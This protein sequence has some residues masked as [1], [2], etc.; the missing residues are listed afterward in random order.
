MM[1]FGDFFTGE[2]NEILMVEEGTMMNFKEKC[3]LLTYLQEKSYVE[4]FDEKD[5][6]ILSELSYD[7]DAYIRAVVAETLVESSDEKGEQ[8]LLRLTKDHDWLVRTDACDSLCISESVDTY[9]L[10]KEI[11]KKDTSGLVRGYAILSLENIAN[12]INRE[13]ELIEFLEERIIKEKVQFTRINT[14]TALYKLGREK[15]LKNLLSMFNSKKYE[16]RHSVVESLHEIFDDS[17]KNEIITALLEHKKVETAGSVIYRINDIIEEIFLIDLKEK[18]DEKGIDEK[19]FCRLKEISVEGSCNN[20]GL[21]ARVLVNSNLKEGEKILQRLAHDNDL[22]VRME[23]CDSLCNGKS[24]KTYKLLKNIGEKDTSGLVRG[25]AIASLGDVAIEI[26]QQHDLIEFL[27]CRLLNEKVEFARI[28]IFSVLYSLGIEEYLANL[29]SMLNSKRY[30]NRQTVV[31]NLSEI[32]N[33]SNKEV[34]RTTLIEHKKIETKCSV[35]S[36][37]NEVLEQIERD[38]DE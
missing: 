25:Y 22:F 2:C 24:L 31:E 12:R 26:N 35:I 27:K 16:N 4:D 9:N 29:L 7:E 20:R 6:S 36:E 17:N 8:I 32:V 37:I 38:W 19:D 28:Y 3:E 34:I 15:Y 33:D 30:Q 23:V 5:Y 21:A 1:L 18:S 10:L 11:A 14:Y 13:N